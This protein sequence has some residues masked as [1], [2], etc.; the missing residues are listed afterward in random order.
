M[1][2]PRSDRA[3]PE[4][5]PAALPRGLRR[6]LYV[7]ACVTG[8][9]VMIVEIL[10]A[11]MLAPYF[12]TS[13][14]VWTAQIAVTLAALAIGYY[15]G[16]RAADASA[17]VG[18]LFVALTAAGIWLVATVAA[19]DWLASSFLSLPLPLGSLLA[20]VC[21]FFVPLSLLATTGP[22]LVRI[23]AQSLSGVGGTAG[24]ISFTSTLGSFVGTAAIGYLL[25]PL[26]PNSWT[27]DGTAGALFLVSALYVVTWGRRRGSKTG[28]VLCIAAAGALGWFGL[29]VDGPR[30]PS[31]TE[32]YRGNSAF[33]VLQVLQP[34]HG[35]NRIYLTDYLVQNVYDTV[36]RSSPVMFTYMLEGLARAY[37]PRLEDVLCIGVGIGIVPRDLAAQGARVDAVEI[38]ASSIE[39]A[40]R[41]FGL[42]TGEFQLTIGDGRW[43]LNSTR[44]SYDA[45]IIDAFVGDGSPSH[46][47]S[48]EAFQE[49]RRIL[50]RDGVLVI[51]TFVD[52][53]SPGDFAGAS[54]FRT[55][56]A[57]FSSVRAHGAPA[58]NTLF[59]ASD[60][61]PLTILHEP[62]Y[63]D[64]HPD[65]IA[66]VRAAFARSW[67]P[68]ASRGIVLTD[69]YNPL[70]YFDAANRE[71][72]RRDMA[73]TMKTR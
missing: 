10:G 59:V 35:T 6:F 2:D 69:D 45:V 3:R 11:K 21:L 17:R 31:D 15:L 4:E 16:G 67:V 51:N 52:F 48:R 24:R 68:D 56:Q 33:G 29:T 8:A 43:F 37:A 47:M 30:L 66:D 36:S 70:E 5:P 65:A 60:R 44:R 54:L 9:A 72:Y 22:F 25:I 12:G 27:M 39:V 32:L 42:D 19:R 53:N 34:G 28:I 40:R 55:L 58:T 71:R 61:S 49:V 64:V 57:V 38:N 7:T 18:R 20:A 62:R 46:L 1:K 13:H 14:F 26:L 63:A 23:V 41:Y 73:M 50:K